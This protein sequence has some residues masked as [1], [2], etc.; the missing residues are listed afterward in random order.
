MLRFINMPLVVAPTDPTPPSPRQ[1]GGAKLEATI[2]THWRSLDTAW[3][4]LAAD[5]TPSLASLAAALASAAE[6]FQCFPFALIWISCCE[7][8]Q[9]RARLRTSECRLEKIPAVQDQNLAAI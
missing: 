9:G 3:P 1:C 7:L 8:L 4:S 5:L 6:L 2:T